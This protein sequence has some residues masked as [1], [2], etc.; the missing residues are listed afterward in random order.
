MR[1]RNA[2]DAIRAAC[3]A[4]AELAKRAPSVFPT[5][6]SASRAYQGYLCDEYGVVDGIIAD[7]AQPLNMPVR[8]ALRSWVENEIARLPPRTDPDSGAERLRQWKLIHALADI[9][10]AE[11]DVDAY[12]AAQQR[13]G[14]RV[15]DD[16]GM[17]PGCSMPDAPRTPTR[18]SKP[19]N[20][21][22]QSAK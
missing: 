13:L 10:D 5:V 19:P 11:A 9:A 2:A 17:A 16:A 7:F 1:P 3:T 21:T 14:P 20:R 22:R 8:A 15:R 18:P 4:A 12:C 6:R